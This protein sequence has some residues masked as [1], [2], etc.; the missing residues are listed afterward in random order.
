MEPITFT[1]LGGYPFLCRPEQAQELYAA[2]CGLKITT[3]GQLLELC[4]SRESVPVEFDDVQW[5]CISAEVALLGTVSVRAPPP[6]VPEVQYHCGGIVFPN[7]MWFKDP[8][9]R[10]LIEPYF[11]PQ[12]RPA[13]V[14]IAKNTTVANADIKRLFV[15]VASIEVV[16]LFIHIFETDKAAL[17]EFILPDK[18]KRLG[19]YDD[20]RKYAIVLHVKDMPNISNLI[21][22][23]ISAMSYNF[24]AKRVMVQ[25]FAKLF[26][27]RDFPR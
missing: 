8:F 6:P 17:L 11:S 12:H 5:E 7:D 2:L 22:R 16:L 10:K 24:N 23:K 19:G 21:K 9:V 20:E 15:D 1:S 27:P 14:T 13:E 18:Y 25:T 26:V 4:R 3:K